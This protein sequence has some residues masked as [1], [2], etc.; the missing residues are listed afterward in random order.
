MR[1]NQ[2]LNKPPEMIAATL[3]QTA[4]PVANAKSVIHMACS[5]FSSP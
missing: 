2:S 5:A 1:R 4:T 3:R